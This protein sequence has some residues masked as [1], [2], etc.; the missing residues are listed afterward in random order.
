MKKILIVGCGDIGTLVAKS[1]LKQQAEVNALARSAQAV[2][3][4]NQL[5][6][7]PIAGDLD[8]P[9]SLLGLP[10][11]GAWIYYFAPP[12]AKGV[13]DPRMCAFVV[14]LELM[15]APPAGIVYIS[16]SGVYGD[17]NGDWVDENDEPAPVADRARRRLDAE[18]WL[19]GY[20]RNSGVPVIVL[21]VGGIYGPGRLP[22]ER[23]KKGLPV[24]SLAQSSY[25]NR[26]HVDDLVAICVAAVERGLPDRIYNVC[27]DAPSTMTDYF[28]AVAD[29][30]GLP[31]PPEVDL[32]EARRVMSAAMLSYLTESRRML[33]RRMHEELGI[34]LHY[35]DLES[36]LA[37]AVAEGQGGS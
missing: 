7:T 28:F 6:I 9:S 26:I 16:T 13:S 27:D 5:G 30:L 25:T 33:N 20:G 23:L 15:S 21:R 36:G 29:A 32:D 4:L 2:T 18:T 34:E 1:W 3:R 19:R 22:V 17:C 10:A 35:P 37:G 24:L 14:A 31:R 11:A 12:P 8:Q